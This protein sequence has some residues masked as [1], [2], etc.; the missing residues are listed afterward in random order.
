[1]V[2]DEADP[3]DYAC[4]G[5]LFHD[6]RCNG[7]RLR[8]ERMVRRPMKNEPKMVWTPSPKS[9][10]PSAVGYSSPSAPKPACAQRRKTAIGDADAGKDQ[11][12]AEQQAVLEPDSDGAVRAAH[13]ARRN[14]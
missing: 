10:T 14:G 13:R 4:V 9:V 6:D 1:M 5:V 8:S 12:G 11:A 3:H 2:V 7:A